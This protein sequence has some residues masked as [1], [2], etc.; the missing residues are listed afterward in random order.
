MRRQTIGENKSKVFFLSSRKSFLL[1]RST[2]TYSNA[3]YTSPTEPSAP[4]PI[5]TPI[6]PAQGESSTIP[7]EVMITPQEQT[8]GQ[9][10]VQD[11]ARAYKSRNKRPCDFCRYKKAACHLESKP[12]CELCLRYG[13]DCTF[14][15]SPAKRRRPNLSEERPQEPV[16]PPSN[17]FDLGSDLL[18]WE[19][20]PSFMTASLPGG[21][22]GEYKFDSP[23]FAPLMFEQ[24]D[25]VQAGLVPALSH[26]PHTP[27]SAQSI[28]TSFFDNAQEPSL[29]VQGPS[30]AQLVGLSGEYDPYLLRRYQFDGYNECIF[31]TRRL[32]RVG[33]NDKIPVHF[34]IQQNKTIARALPAENLSNSEILRMEVKQM[35]SDDIGKRLIKLY[36]LGYLHFS[37]SHTDNAGS[38]ALF[39]HISRSSLGSAA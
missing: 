30:N 15:E 37:D 12:P 33:E 3:P 25:P 4:W 11:R 35:I 29:D 7:M 21:L 10:D 28:P 19:P 14:V 5:I 8:L 18:S 27:E 23:M 22:P 16:L 26:S 31:R 6:T 34:L 1:A 32:R 9:S 38:S 36:V 24:F 20:L 2:S 13:K 39:S 17:T